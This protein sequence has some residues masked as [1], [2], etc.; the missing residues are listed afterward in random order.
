MLAGAPSNPPLGARLQR[1]LDLAREARVGHGMR[2]LLS[3]G[4]ELS[5]RVLGVGP[6]EIGGIEGF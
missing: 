3:L 1:S 4:F 5:F 2:P 6:L